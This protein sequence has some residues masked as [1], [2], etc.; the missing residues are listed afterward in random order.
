MDRTESIRK[1][2]TGIQYYQSNYEVDTND[3]VE[4]I[5]RLSSQQL[6]EVSEAFNG[7]ALVYSGR[8]THACGI[9]IEETP[10]ES[11]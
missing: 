11:N 4:I 5:I 3:T 1:L 8:P 10:N 6:D 9:A 7:H 2:L